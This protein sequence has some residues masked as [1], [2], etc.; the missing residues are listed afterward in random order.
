M[1]CEHKWRQVTKWGMYKPIGSTG[2]IEAQL[3][4]IKHCALCGQEKVSR[5]A[6][7]RA[8]RRRSS[9]LQSE[10]TS[11][12]HNEQRLTILKTILQQAKFIDDIY[13]A[14]RGK[15]YSKLGKEYGYHQL[16]EHLNSLLLDGLVTIEESRTEKKM[17]EI[18]AVLWPV[19]QYESLRGFIPKQEVKRLLTNSQ[20]VLADALRVDNPGLG[21]EIAF[22]VIHD[23]L[24]NRANE[25]QRITTGIIGTPTQL[26]INRRTKDLNTLKLARKLVLLIEGRSTTTHARLRKELH[27]SINQYNSI[28][29]L[30]K[31]E[32]GV[33]LVYF[34]IFSAATAK[35][36]RKLPFELKELL[37]EAEATLRDLTVKL[38]SQANDGNASIQ[39][40]L[41]TNVVGTAKGFLKKGAMEK[42][43]SEIDA[44]NK[45]KTKLTDTVSSSNFRFVLEN[46][47]FGNYIKI[48]CYESNW[49]FFS[50][51]F[52][53]R[54]AIKKHIPIIVKARNIEAHQKSDPV[55]IISVL[56]S[57]LWLRL[58]IS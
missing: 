6:G 55:D 33:P 38:L 18:K 16:E 49:S 47:Y 56:D 57:L 14:P 45:A 37:Q 22:T 35:K 40:V 36:T 23:Y 52:S 24:K 28:R 11:Y 25:F 12:D 29:K 8:V 21:R 30:L 9:Q 31:T 39:S 17:G 44:L 15:W 46:I 7:T 5:V 54:N 43:L 20:E 19:D 10:K 51:V 27:L 41:P 58:Q 3:L 42:G 53:S 48:I 32:L 13:I 1:T 4:Q 2:L 26:E 34:G 50:T